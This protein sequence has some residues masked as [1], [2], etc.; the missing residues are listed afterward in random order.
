MNIIVIFTAKCDCKAA[1]S[2]FGGQFED[3]GETDARDD[4]TE[5]EFEDSKT[6]KFKLI[7]KFKG[8]SNEQF[9][10]ANPAQIWRRLRPRRTGPSSSSKT[11][12]IQVDP[13]SQSPV[14]DLED[15]LPR[16]SPS[17]RFMPTIT[18]SV[19][20]LHTAMLEA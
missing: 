3:L 19:T 15:M 2:R 11:K 16:G 1:K 6:K 17:S 12:K 13:E 8:R 7:R 9:K 20:R 18:T 4:G 5:S 10:D 14:K